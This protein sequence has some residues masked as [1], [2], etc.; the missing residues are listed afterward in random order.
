MEW[1]RLHIVL[2]TLHTVDNTT[3]ARE[4]SI[5]QCTHK[6]THYYAYTDYWRKGVQ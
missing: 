5:L 1:N 6:T 4:Y 3:G 2:L